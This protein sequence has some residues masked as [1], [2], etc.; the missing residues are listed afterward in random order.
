MEKSKMIVSTIP[1]GVISIDLLNYLKRRRYKGTVIVTCRTPEEAH[2]CY[3]A[4]ASFVIVPN[5]LGAERFKGLLKRKKTS[6][7]AWMEA[8]K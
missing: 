5:V 4:G 1:D 6:R 2:E 7:K 8:I 3:E